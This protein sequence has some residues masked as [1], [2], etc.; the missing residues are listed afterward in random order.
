MAMT[1]NMRRFIGAVDELSN[2]PMGTEGMGLLWGQPGEGKSTAIAYVI[3]AMNGVYARAMSSWTVTSML[4]YLCKELGGHR[5]LRRA[6]MVDY[7]V[8]QLCENPRPVFIDEADHIFDKPRK[9]EMAESL[10]DIYDISGCPVI[11]CGM[12]DIARI[13]QGH[14]RFARRITQWVEFTGIDLA[15][16]RTVV[17]TIS[18]IQIEEDLLQ[19]MHEA[20]GG[21][22]GRMVVAISKIERMAKTSGIDSVSADQWGDRTMFYDQPTFGGSAQRKGKK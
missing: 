5:M 3:N 21:N 1:K 7:I 10:R 15:D 8:E 9:F 6:D 22:I 18:E 17:E 19:H 12:E 13:I 2:R 11:L 14:G 4:G 16:A 20:T